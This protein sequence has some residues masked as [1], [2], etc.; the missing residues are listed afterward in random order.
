MPI[1]FIF[2]TIHSRAC[3]LVL[4]DFEVLERF[5]KYFSLASTI[6]FDLLPLKRTPSKFL[7]ICAALP[8]K[9]IP[10]FSKFFIALS[11]TTARDCGVHRQKASSAKSFLLLHSEK[12]C[13]NS[14]KR[15]CIAGFFCSKRARICGI[16]IGIFYSQAF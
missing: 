10:V 3:S 1:P 13:L 16:G 11:Q 7:S 6:H 15:F 4:K 9:R 8:E 5:C 12:I 2:S 14:F